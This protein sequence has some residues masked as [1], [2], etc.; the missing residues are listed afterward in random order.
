MFNYVWWHH[1]VDGWEILHHQKDGWKPMNNGIKHRFQLVQ[2]FA[3]IHRSI[4][5]VLDMMS[6][7]PFDI[8]HLDMIQP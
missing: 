5:K 7:M 6:K 8:N 4:I 1:T 3:T 2:D